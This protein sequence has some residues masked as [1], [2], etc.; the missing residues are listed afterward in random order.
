MKDTRRDVC[1]QFTSQKLSLHGSSSQ[2]TAVHIN[3]YHTP[4]S[5]NAERQT[6]P[7][8]SCACPANQQTTPK[9][10]ALAQNPSHSSTASRR[11][12]MVLRTEVAA[13]VFTLH[14]PPAML[15]LQ[16]FA[17][18]FQIPTAV[19][20]TEFLPQNGHVYMACWAISIFFTCFRSEEP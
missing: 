18:H 4:H 2:Q 17:L 11:R 14:A 15:L 8:T 20:L 10:P 19:L 7:T 1:R 3:A 12:R 6:N 13:C 16:V 9:P 5:N